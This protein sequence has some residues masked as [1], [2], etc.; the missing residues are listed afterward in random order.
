MMEKRDIMSYNLEELKME[1]LSKG[2]KPFRAK[3]IYEWFHKRHIE[4]F[5]EMT[6]ISKDFKKVLKENYDIYI[7]RIVKVYKSKLDGTR[8]YL[9]EL[10]D[11]K[12]IESVFMRYKHG[13]SVCISSQVGCRMG[14][15]FC[16]STIDG[17]ERN[18]TAS[19]MLGQ[20]YMMQKET[21][22]R[23]SNVVIMGSGEPFDN[24]D[25]FLKFI[26][27]VTGEDGINISA[28]NITVSTCGLVDKIRDLAN[29]NLQ[30]TLAI[31]LHSP[32]DELRKNIMPIANKYKIEDIIDACKYYFSKT[33]RRISFEYSL[34]KDVN[35]TVE[36]AKALSSLIKGMNVHVNLI[37]VNP[38][39]ERDYTHSDM[40]F[41]QNFKN[42]LEKYKINVTIRR[43]M[44]ADIN[45]ACGQLRK[46]YI[47][48]HKDY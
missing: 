5:D 20:I 10:H 38:I 22:E 9:F 26:S 23:V 39:K 34:I 18:L 43:E 14:C 7:P 36:C 33:R 3:Q 13:N 28:R 48:E 16:A 17:L 31:S 11:G 27:M 8:K 42:I 46:S 41:I 15:K 44:G 4:S 32:T 45:A 6:N 37:P 2:Q 29:K 35:D 25:N 30:I 12:V 1:I 24:Y 19:E 21:N 40:E 47:D